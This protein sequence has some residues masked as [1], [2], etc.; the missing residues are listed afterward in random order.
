MHMFPH[1]MPMKSPQFLRYFSVCTGILL[2]TATMLCGVT[3]PSPE[4]TR[5]VN[6]GIV[7][8]HNAVIDSENN[9]IIA[10]GNARCISPAG[11]TLWNKPLPLTAKALTRDAAGNLYATGW[12]VEDPPH[13]TIGNLGVIKLSPGGDTLWMRSVGATGLSDEGTAIVVDDQGGIYAGGYSVGPNPSGTNSTDIYLVKYNAE[14]VQQWTRRYN[15]A[16]NAE[17]QLLDLVA[18]P[19]GG[20]V[21]TGL[22]RNPAEMFVTIRYSAAGT[23]QW[24]AYYDEPVETEKAVGGSIV[25][26]SDG[27]V[28]IAGT[29]GSDF[30][31]VK[32]SATGA[33]LWA[34]RPPVARGWARDIIAG[35]DGGAIVLSGLSTV[36]VTAIGDN[37]GEAWHAAARTIPSAYIGLNWSIMPLPGGGYL[38]SSGESTYGKNY[39]KLV[40]MDAGGGGL[41]EISWPDAMVA[42]AIGC[43]PMR[44]APDGSVWAVATGYV[45]R[46]G[47]I[48]GY[49]EGTGIPIMVTIGFDNLQP[50]SVRLKATVNPHGAT[51]RYFFSHGPTAAYGSTT[52]QRTLAAESVPLNAFEAAVPVTPGSTWHFRL[53]AWNDYGSYISTNQTFTVPQNAYQLWTINAFGSV[54]APG[55]GPGDD[56][57]LDGVSNLVEYSFGGNPT[58][59]GPVSGLPVM[60]FFEDP[61]SGFTFPAI[62]WRPDTSRTDVTITPVASH[63]LVTW[64]ANGIGT[65]GLPDG[66][67]RSVL[68]GTQRFMRLNIT[69]P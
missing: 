12:T 39:C 15:G 44:T 40:T 52:P 34:Y 41:T 35:P 66:S 62:T 48:P 37:G 42:G 5:S 68:Q 17:D 26:T 27:G 10:S 46:F 31:V 69:S 14:G 11:I 51:T 21:L 24:A 28:A 29:V 3:L 57:D 58:A 23:P 55:S 18:M 13:P 16:A 47:T 2:S 1:S 65:T 61:D 4:S 54:S 25:R 43:G 20:V 59:A 32:Y 67:R 30:A 49:V 9:L 45:K 6:T 50:A 7:T 63:D 53:E 56:P 36:S 33:Q 38:V 8:K 64:S 19:G 22:T 60:S